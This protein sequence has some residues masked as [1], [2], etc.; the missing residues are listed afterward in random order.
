VATNLS[1]TPAVRLKT[2][3]FHVSLRGGLAGSFAINF[4]FENDPERRT[5]TT[6]NIYR[7]EEQIP[8]M[9]RYST[10]LMLLAVLSGSVDPSFCCVSGSVISP[11]DPDPY[12]AWGVKIAVHKF[13]NLN[14]EKDFRKLSSSY[15]YR[16]LV[17]EKHF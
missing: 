11:K 9:Y 2:L 5:R 8:M 4:I 14:R 1:S 10:Q 12:R 16:I 17:R 13:G 3:S 6:E 7:G 15:L